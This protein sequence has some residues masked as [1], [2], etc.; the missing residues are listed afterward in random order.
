MMG[1]NKWHWA[2]FALVMGISVPAWAQ[3]DAAAGTDADAAEEGQRTAGIDD[4]TEEGQKLR[5]RIKSVQRK[6]FI[7]KARWELYP[8]VSFTLNDPFFQNVLVGGSLSY[9]LSD[10]FSLEAGGAYVVARTES[11]VVQFIRRETDS[12]LEDPPQLEYKADLNFVWAPI[13]GKF[14]LFGDAIIHFDTYL[15]LGGGVF[16][17]DLQPNPAAN[18]G[19]GTRLF[20]TKWLAIRTEFR[21]YFFAEERAGESDLQTPA[22]LGASLALFLPPKFEYEFQ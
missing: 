17:T 16:G 7:K 14:S 4:E 3:E 12:L 8:L 15:T 6:V 9:H 11:S 21:N 18:V 20:L 5:D 22:F 13:Y 2:T 10:A 19:V 1:L